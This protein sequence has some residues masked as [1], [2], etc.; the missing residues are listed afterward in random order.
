MQT[1]T[2]FEFKF[3]FPFELELGFLLELE[4][5]FLL[6]FWIGLEIDFDTRECGIM[7]YQPRRVKAAGLR[8]LKGG[9]K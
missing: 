7:K 3:G 9:N 5:R 6:G 8:R 4:L 2:V 1:I